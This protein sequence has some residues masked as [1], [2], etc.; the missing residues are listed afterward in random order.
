MPKRALRA[1]SLLFIQLM[2]SRETWRFSYGRKCFK[3]KLTRTL[4]NLP[5]DGEDLDEDAMGEVISSTSYWE[6]V[7]PMIKDAVPSSGDM[8]SM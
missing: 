6:F 1:T 8:D 4:I 3:N 7:R 5:V 2:L